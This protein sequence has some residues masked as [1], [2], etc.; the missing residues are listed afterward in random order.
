MRKTFENKYFSIDLHEQWSQ[1]FSDGYN[2][3]EF[4][5]IR[6]S[7][8]KEN[9]HGMF[10]IEIYVLGLGIRLYWT[11]NKEMLEERLEHYSK[12]LRDPSQWVEHH[13]D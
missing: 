1:F 6:L 3:Q 11:W 5:I 8:E 2:W 9:V 12:I 7:F 13:D 10:E 4:D